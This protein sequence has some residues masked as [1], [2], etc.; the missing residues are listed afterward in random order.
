MV[1]FSGAEHD[2]DMVV[3]AVRQNGDAL[4]FASEELTHD[5]DVLMEAVRQN[6][7]ALRLSLIHI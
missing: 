4:Q 5:R 2:R 3:E 7:R 6:G 1:C